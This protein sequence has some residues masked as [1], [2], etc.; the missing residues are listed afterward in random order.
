MAYVAYDH[1]LTPDKDRVVPVKQFA[2]TL[3]KALAAAD[4]VIAAGG[5]FNL[6]IEAEDGH[7]IFSEAEL[8]ARFPARTPS[9]H[10]MPL[11]AAAAPA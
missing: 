8:R 3:E 11:A 4:A 7:T 1:A 6:R 5:F 2:P 10:A 9:W